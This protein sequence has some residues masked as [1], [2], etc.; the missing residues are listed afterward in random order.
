[1]A[2]SRF[3][4]QARFEGDSS[5]AVRASKQFQR[6]IDE[7]GGSLKDVVVGVAG[8]E[9][10]RRALTFAVREAS[11]AEDASRK[12][13]VALQGLGP[14]A[15]AAAAA[16]ERQANALAAS[17]RFQD[18]AVSAAQ[19]RLATIA[20]SRAE[21]ESLTAAAADLAAGLGIGIEDAAGKLAQALAGSKNPLK[22][23]GID[24]EGAAKSS[25]RLASVLDGVTQKFGGQ[26]A[27]AAQTFGGIMARLSNQVGEAAEA[28]G[29]GVIS[30]EELRSALTDTISFLSSADTLRAIQRYGEMFSEVLTPAIAVVR[31]LKVALDAI[32]TGIGTVITALPGFQ[33]GLG[34]VEANTAAVEATA[35]R[36]GITVEEV[37]AR[38][39]AAKGA[40]GAMSQVEESAAES[41]RKLTLS[42]EG[43]SKA[44]ANTKGPAEFLAEALNVVTSAQLE[45]EI[46][47]IGV[48][49]DGA[50]ASGELTFQELGVLS[51]QAEA[52]MT[53]LRERIDR[54]KQ[55]LPDIAPAAEQGL[56]GAAESAAALNDQLER[57]VA[58][59]D[60]TRQAL[61]A[62]AAQATLTARQFDAL[63]ASAAAA[64][65]AQGASSGAASLAGNAAAV[66]AALSAGGRLTQGGTRIRLPGGGSRLVRSGSSFSSLSG[67]TFATARSSQSVSSDGR[68]GG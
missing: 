54:L 32:G 38:M 42:L 10:L 20:G 18:D 43:L 34:N 56:G 63:A 31:G 46:I 13:R 2:D 24:T 47:K 26:A 55:G 53:A 28:F 1:M 45:A 29:T 67:G 37:R 60:S 17:T 5:G 21:I 30:S 25:E 61:A 65:A 50:R 14:D 64:A 41:T 33:S 62:T 22:A 59:G 68:I 44:A 27:A 40:V 15:E 39:E 57:S 12:L 6:S 58:L 23:F 52:K 49:L 11:D 51:E 16:L 7:I 19:T 4:V 48:A 3:V 66:D 9:A 36:L 35:K 8:F